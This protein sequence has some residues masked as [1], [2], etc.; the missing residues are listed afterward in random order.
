MKGML[1]MERYYFPSISRFDNTIGV[2]NYNKI[3]DRK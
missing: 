2:E 1:A 3:L